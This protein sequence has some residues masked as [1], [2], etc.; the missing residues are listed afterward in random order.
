MSEATFVVYLVLLGVL[1]VYG[2]HRLWFVFR[3]RAWTSA[4]AAAQSDAADATAAA[5]APYVTVQLPIYNERTVA[6]RLIRSAARLDHPRE[7]FEIQVLDDSTDETRAIVD[8][9]VA[10]LVAQ[11]IDAKVLRRDDRTGFKA[12]ALA[13]GLASARGELVAIFD[14]DFVPEP[15]FLRRLLPCFADPRV[16]MAQA[17]WGHE[18]RCDGM[19]TR[20]QATLLDGHFA[21]EHR[22]RHTQGLYFNFNGTAGLWR[23]S[24]IADAGG[25]QHD[26]LTED[27]DL[28]YRAQL[29][30][31]RFDYRPEVVAPAELPPDILAFKSQQH[32]WAKGSV[33]VARKLLVEIWRAPVPLRNKLE[34]T[35]HLTGNIGY[36]LVLALVLCVPLALPA[37][38]ALPW[39]AH[40]AMFCA[41]TL[42]VAVFYAVGQRAV[43]RTVLERVLDVPSAIA[44]GIGMSV[45]QTLAVF[46]GWFGGTGTFVRTPKR[47]NAR[48]GRGYRSMLKGLPGIELVVAAWVAFALWRATGE[49]LWG[50]LP[51][52]ALFFWGFAWVGVLSLREVLRVQLSR[53]RAA[54][55][56]F[57]A[58]AERAAASELTPE[59]RT[60]AAAS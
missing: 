19:F 10:A 41:S 18:N 56:E 57:A 5:D 11:G 58:A 45:A 6:A 53:L 4:S 46:E 2:L 29:A 40:A 33:Q 44:L 23:K 12:G 55:A 3:F 52:L 59:P 20:A 1:A 26:T 21:L 17:R 9:E 14:A 15:D 42:S 7:R 48:G 24:A 60:D 28:S 8:R 43:G 34:A 27:L 16:A 49:R 13:A 50:T 25:W 54:P 37:I 38:E 36:P 32:R 31:W 35:A 39:W 22:V 47:G 30:G 51:F